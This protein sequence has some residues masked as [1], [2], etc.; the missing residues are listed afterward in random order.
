M[1]G[2]DLLSCSNGIH[3]SDSKLHQ[4]RFDLALGNISLLGGWS[5]IR[6]KPSRDVVNAPCLSR[7]ETPLN[8][9]L[10]NI[11]SLSDNPG[12]VTQ[13]AQMN[14]AGSLQMK[15]FVLFYSVLCYSNLI[16]L[17]S[18]RICSK[19][20]IL[21]HFFERYQIHDSVSNHF[22]SP[23]QLQRGVME[24]FQWV[25]SI[26]PASTSY[27]QVWPRRVVHCALLNFC[28]WALLPRDR[29]QPASERVACPK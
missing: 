12:M 3:G 10:N 9:V 18:L 19:C 17:Y 15:Y 1:G 4:G 16:S 25:P 5:T 26:Q 2:T 11:L 28:G 20:S 29:G 27:N 6:K 23:V 13:L 21:L 7:F 22:P 8:N 14:T 24:R